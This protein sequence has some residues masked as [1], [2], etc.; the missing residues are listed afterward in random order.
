MVPSVCVFI[1]YWQNPESKDECLRRLH[2]WGSRGR[3]IHKVY[4]SRSSN[5]VGNVM[6]CRL[7]LSSHHH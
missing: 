6:V 5:H 1:C 2:V 3:R 7:L 4:L